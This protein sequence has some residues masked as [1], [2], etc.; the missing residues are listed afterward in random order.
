M[1]KYDGEELINVG[2]G[3]EISIKTLAYNIAATVGFETENIHWDASKPN[4]TMRKVMDVSKIKSLGWEPK[5]FINTGLKSS[6][7]DFLKRYG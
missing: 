7:E 4:G 6:Y 3:K 1:Q 5:V 2:S